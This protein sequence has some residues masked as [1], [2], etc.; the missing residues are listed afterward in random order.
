M[1]TSEQVARLAG[2]SRATVSRVLNGSSNV[3]EETRKRIYAAIATL[4]YG[5]NILTTGAS[6]NR[7]HTIALAL[8]SDDGLNFTHLTDTRYYFYLKLLQYI[9]REAAKERY[10]LLL[11]PLPYGMLAPVD[12]PETTYILALQTKH[13]SGVIALALNSTDPR[14]QALCHSSIPSIFVDS[15]L[16]GTNTTYVKSDYMD[17]ARQATEHLLQLGHRRIAFF[18][19]EAISIAGAER[20]MGCQQTMAHAGLVINPNFIR[21]SGW[22]LM[23]GYQAAMTFLNEHHDVTAI[24]A[25]SD[26]L[27]LGIQRALRKH[28][29]HVPEDI[30]LIGFDDIDLSETNDPPLTT[31]RQ[32]TQALSEGAVTRLL[33]MTRGEKT[34][35]PLIASTQLIVRAST[36]SIQK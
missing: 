21:P 31:I 12:D 13:V 11:P 1:V 10:D 29:L 35:A 30:S 20:L 23:D 5:T 27:A 32:D 16:E 36:R 34:P 2:V 19:G 17:G 26:M 18:P 15:R 25:G 9:E 24:V 28:N 14:I 3:S 22:N 7:S 6:L 4:G 8:S 33:Q